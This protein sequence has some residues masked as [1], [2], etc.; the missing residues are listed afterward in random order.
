VKLALAMD[1]A[2]EGGVHSHGRRA[3]S[4]G[5]EPTAL[6]QVALLALPTLGFAHAGAAYAWIR[7]RED[8][9]SDA[10]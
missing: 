2:S 8:T 3:A 6:E 7:D 9:A 10:R 4:E 1:A 5:I